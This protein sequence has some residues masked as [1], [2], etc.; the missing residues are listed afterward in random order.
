[1]KT[2]LVYLFLFLSLTLTNCNG[3]IINEKP[4]VYYAF[5]EK[6]KLHSI[7]LKKLLEAEVIKFIDGDTIKV[8][9]LDF[10]RKLNKIETIRF[11]G[12]DTPE[13]V[14]PKKIV[15]YFGKEASE[16]TKQ[17][18]SDEIVYLGFDNDLRDKYGR[19]L[20]YCYTKDGTFINYKLI[21]DGYGYAYL[22]YPFV[23]EKEFKEAEKTARTKRLG[24]WKPYNK[25]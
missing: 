17:L 10:N 9:L 20:C 2:K 5:L 24:L 15:Q 16:Y 7:E 11:I 18:L 23:Y 25:L 21:A 22:K 3:N 14:H 12:V 13:T 1:M 6:E 4:L 8:E 19:L